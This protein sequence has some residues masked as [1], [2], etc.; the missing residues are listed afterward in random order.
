MK[1]ELHNLS[2]REAPHGKTKNWKIFWGTTIISIV[3]EDDIV[4]LSFGCFAIAFMSLFLLIMFSGEKGSEHRDRP[5]NTVYIEGYIQ[6][7]A[8]GSVIN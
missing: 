5:I 1:Q 6:G 8:V 7:V 3:M 4:R 2:N